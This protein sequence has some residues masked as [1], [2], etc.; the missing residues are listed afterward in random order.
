MIIHISF[1]GAKKFR[2]FYN[3]FLIPFSRKAELLLGIC[4]FSATARTSPCICGTDHNNKT[5][6]SH[7]GSPV[8]VF[9][10]KVLS[11]TESAYQTFL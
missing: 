4:T 3:N 1:Y 10:V 8:R 5:D 2:H 6:R 7:I 9:S 11:P